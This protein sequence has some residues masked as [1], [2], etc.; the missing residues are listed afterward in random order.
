MTGTHP[1]RQLYIFLT[2]K[3]S[4]D[5]TC[6]V[7]LLMLHQH[8]WRW[9]V[10]L[11]GICHH[12]WLI[13]S[14]LIV[15]AHLGLGW[16][17][18]LN[19]AVIILVLKIHNWLRP[20]LL[21]V[22]IE[23]YEL[24][25]TGMGLTLQVQC[26]GKVVCTAVQHEGLLLRV[27]ACCLIFGPLRNHFV[28]CN[29]RISGDGLRLT[30]FLRSHGLLTDKLGTLCV[31]FWHWM[32]NTFGLVVSSQLR[33]FGGLGTRSEFLIATFLKLCDEERTVKSPSIMDSWLCN[34]TFG[35]CIFHQVFLWFDC[36]KSLMLNLA[37]TGVSYAPSLYPRWF[38]KFRGLRNL[39]LHWLWR[40]DHWWSRLPIVI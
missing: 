20:L 8:T 19:H 10:Y 9:R 4:N 1:V 37:W 40:H 36:C 26:I 13:T 2:V 11:N 5:R 35:Y 28:D 24:S 30:C 25:G 12:Q 34:G 18:P 14:I 38:C 31:L 27:L 17:Y 16:Q 22:S 32:I 15:I 39:M 3:I 29:T 33:F 7:S 23:G 6:Q 21:S